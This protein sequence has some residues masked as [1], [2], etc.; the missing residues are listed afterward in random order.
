MEISMFAMGIG[1]L[2]LVGLMA[3]GMHVAAVMFFLAA[4]AA[5]LYLGPEAL[6]SYGTQYWSST[7]NYVLVAIPLFVLLGE[8]LV[9]GGF[10]DRMYQSLADWLNP[11]PGGLLHT[12]IGASAIFAAVSGSSVATAATI[13]TVAIPAFRG[14][15]YDPKLVL[16]TVA[17]GATLGILIPPSINMIIYGAMTSTSVGRLY[18]AG[19]IPGLLLT[20]LFSLVVIVMCWYKPSYAGAREPAAPLA[21]RLRRLVNLIP[22]LVIFGIVMGSIYAGWATPTEAAGVGVL[23]SL[24]FAALYRTVSIKMLH[25]CFVVTTYVSAMIM[26]IAVSA[27][28]LN[29]VLGIMGVPQAMAEFVSGLGTSQLQTHHRPGDPLPDPRL[30]HGCVG[31]DHRHDPGRHAARHRSQDR[32]GLVRHLP[33]HNGRNGAHHASGGHESLR[34]SGDPKGRFNLRSH[35]RRAAV[36]LDDVRSR[37]PVGRL[38]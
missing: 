29:F 33:R 3:V 4:I 15:G 10:T 13:G 11:L 24:A 30:L 7:N 32:P 1:F 26:L 35:H 38:A 23:V 16:G 34:G 5:T 28:Y 22:P 37:L 36:S 25:E 27:F 6:L 12:N 31:D 20:A 14:R 2:L 17:A 21:F 18:A 9:R 19:I 8:I